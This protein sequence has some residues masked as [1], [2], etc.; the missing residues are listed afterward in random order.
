MLISEV[1]LFHVYAVQGEKLI[2][3]LL[4]QERQVH[5]RAHRPSVKPLYTCCLPRALR[6][7]VEGSEQDPVP[8]HVPEVPLLG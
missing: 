1:L 3:Q 6:E 2:T 8:V 7:A 4:P 5:L